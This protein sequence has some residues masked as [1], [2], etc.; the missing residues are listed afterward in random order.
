MQQ[1]KSEIALT[2]NASF[3]VDNWIARLMISANEIADQIMVDSAVDNALRANYAAFDGTFGVPIPQAELMS[4][5]YGSFGHKITGIS[6]RTSQCLPYS[7]TNRL[8]AQSLKRNEGPISG[9]SLMEN[10]GGDDFDDEDDM[11][12]PSKTP[13]S[14]QLL[15]RVLLIL[16]LFGFTYPN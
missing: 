5:H 2:G 8:K 1:R 16:N 9:V 6:P 15:V 11:H 10:R 14:E 3:D 7:Y 13:S 4:S 12:T